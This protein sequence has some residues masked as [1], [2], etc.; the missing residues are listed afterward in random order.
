MTVS[1]MIAAWCAFA[2]AVTAGCLVPADRLPARLPNDKLLHLLSYAALALPVAAL[3]STIGQTAAGAVA[4]LLAGLLIEITQHFVPGRSF[5][6][7]DLIANAA[8]VSIGTVVG[9]LVTL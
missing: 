2:L 7:R 1:L 9:L 5:C 8:G 6:I 4:L 3:P